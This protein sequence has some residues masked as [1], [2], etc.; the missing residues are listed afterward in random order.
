MQLKQQKV[1]PLPEI[2]AYST[3]QSCQL[4]LVIEEA[5]SSYSCSCY[6]LPRGQ[7]ILILFQAIRSC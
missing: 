6:Q 4:L 5:E 1:A 3:R 2:S 7:R